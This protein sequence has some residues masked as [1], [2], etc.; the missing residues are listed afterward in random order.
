MCKVLL[1]HV[2]D[3]FGRTNVLLLG[4][5][6]K[7]DMKA[8]ATVAVPTMATN[9]TTAMALFAPYVVLS[10]VPAGGYVSLFPTG[11]VELFGVQQFAN[12]NGL[13]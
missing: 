6:P 7:C 5:F 3:P 11:I 4:T 12:V 1:G 2:A 8:C 9:K 10:S 13:L